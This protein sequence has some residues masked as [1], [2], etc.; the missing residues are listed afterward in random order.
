MD[1]QQAF[2]TVARHLL[3]QGCKSIGPHGCAYRGEGGKKCAIGALIPDDLYNRSFEGNRIFPLVR[4]H[5]EIG[6]LLEDVSLTMLDELQIV[7]DHTKQPD[8]LKF[9]LT[10]LKHRLREVGR[11]G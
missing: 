9:D 4:E 7:H 3:T 11:F 2:D 10:T 6:V 5:V 1:N 8:G